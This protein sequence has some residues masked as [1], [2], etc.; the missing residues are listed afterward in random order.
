MPAKTRTYELGLLVRS[1]VDGDTLKGDIDCSLHTWIHNKSVRLTGVNAPEKDS[2][3]PLEKAA[4]LKVKDIVSRLFPAGSVAVVAT[5]SNL[6]DKYGRLPA[7]VWIPG[8]SI[9]L[10]D[11]L[12]EHRLVEEYHG[13]ARKPFDNGF[14][15]A[16][17]DLNIEELLAKVAAE[18][19]PDKK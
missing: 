6:E 5:A 18:Q 13:E 2:H 14:L 4:G 15:Q 10:N 19:I 16:I 11:W 8:T 3:E 7:V 12:L 1:V 9:K 17:L